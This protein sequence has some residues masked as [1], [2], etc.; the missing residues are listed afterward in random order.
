MGLFDKIKKVAPTVG[1]VT[2]SGAAAATGV[3]AS[4]ALAK[5][6]LPQDEANNKKAEST[7]SPAN[8]DVAS[9]DS[10]TAVSPEVPPVTTPTAKVEVSEPQTQVD[11]SPDGSQAIV[12]AD[13]DVVF[14]DLGGTTFS[15]KLPSEFPWDCMPDAE[16]NENNPLNPFAGAVASAGTE[17]PFAG[18]VASAGAENP[19]AGAVASAGAYETSSQTLGG[20]FTSIAALRNNSHDVN[21]LL[22]TVQN[23]T[24]DPNGLIQTLSSQT[25]LSS[26]TTQILSQ[27]STAAQNGTLDPNSLIQVLGNQTGMSPESAQLLNQLSTAAQNRTI[28]PDL[29][30]SLGKQ[31]GIPQ[32]G[33]V[34]GAYE[35]KLGWEA[36]YNKAHNG[37]DEIASGVSLESEASYN[38]NVFAGAY[39]KGNAG[40]EWNSDQV[41]VNASTRSMVGIEASQD[42]N[43]KGRLNIEGIEHQPGADAKA[44]TRAFAGAELEGQ[45]DAVFSKDA[46]HASLGANA[47]AGVKAEAQA[48]A[49]L[50]V[51]GD[52]FA[53]G[54][55]RGGAWAGVGAEAG[56]DIGYQDGQINFG[57]NA[58]AALGVGYGY[59]YDVSVD[60]PGIVTHPDAVIEGVQEEIQQYAMEK[61]QNYIP[62][63]LDVNQVVNDFSTDPSGYMQQYSVQQAQEYIP[64]LQEV[65]QVIE[66]V[67]EP[68]SVIEDIGDSIGGLF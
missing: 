68:V 36:N 43:Y 38:A 65:T 55:A 3:Y 58:G 34:K 5:D 25:G 52:D 2:A 4:Q 42:A 17:N 50:S 12:E 16:T 39:S 28:D 35:E 31:A 60:A 44:S 33:Q 51:N 49:A 9:P 56:A 10:S 11:E 64:V 61:A 40:V 18:A 63:S 29:I 32:E 30:Q 48:N 1:A 26:E 59:S 66:V 53:R 21:E 19:F 24:L 41:H 20:L 8:P 23:G 67:N 45:G 27:L 13:G 6:K 46:A 7:P 62:V 54:E 15:Q 14:Q 57:M 22:T 47:F 37:S